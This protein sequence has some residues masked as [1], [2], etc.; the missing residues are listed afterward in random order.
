MVKVGCCVR[1]GVVS[2]VQLGRKGFSRVNARSAMN[3]LKRLLGD[4]GTPWV[5]C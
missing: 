3:L 4:D 1:I 5:D 2:S